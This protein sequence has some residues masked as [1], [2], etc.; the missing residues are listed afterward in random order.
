MH[1]DANP[2]VHHPGVGGGFQHQHGQVVGGI[3]AVPLHTANGQALAAK[4]A[5]I[6]QGHAAPV[7]ELG[8]VVELDVLHFQQLQRKVF[9]DA[10]V[11]FVVGV[12][13][14]VHPAIGDGV[15]V[16]LHADEH[17]GKVEQLQRLPECLGRAAC[18]GMAVDGDLLQLCFPLGVRLLGG[19][20]LGLHG[21]PLNVLL[22]GAV[23]DDDRLIEFPLGAGL[24]VVHIQRGQLLFGPLQQSVKAQPH[25]AGV[26]HGQVAG[27]RIVI[28]VGL[29]DLLARLGALE[30]V[31]VQPDVD[32][33]VQ[34]A[35]FP[36]AAQV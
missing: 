13:P 15:A 2:G 35:A 30:L 7:F 3:G 18:H 25:Q 28:E 22:H 11:G 19:H 16:G 5:A 10:L 36:P 17:G 31:I 1:P 12:K 23:H 9:G 6:A 34:R 14:L 20:F 33:I 24:G 27:T 8:G 21:I 26:I 4:A 29:V 32:V